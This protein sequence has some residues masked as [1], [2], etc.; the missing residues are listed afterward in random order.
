MSF[1]INPSH[2][3]ALLQCVRKGTRTEHTK[4]RG[5]EIKERKAAKEATR[6]VFC[7]YFLLLED[8][9]WWARFG[10]RRSQAGK[11]R[12]KVKNR[13]LGLPSR[14]HHSRCLCIPLYVCWRILT[15]PFILKTHTHTYVHT[16]AQTQ[17][18]NEVYVIA[19]FLPHPTLG[20]CSHL[21]QQVGEMTICLH[22][23]TAAQ[24]LS[25]RLQEGQQRAGQRF[26]T[27]HKI[28]LFMSKGVKHGTVMSALVWLVGE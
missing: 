18:Q 10:R 8:A 11:E 24:S 15:C 27:W 28:I 13:F 1:F 5:K 21:P 16:R 9:L 25:R 22:T 6:Q 23:T 20:L 12:V 3:A 7:A 2:T 4:L 14:M 17:L 19:R 26:E